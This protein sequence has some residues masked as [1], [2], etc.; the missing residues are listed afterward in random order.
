M[1]LLDN[2]EVESFINMCWDSWEQGWHESN[3]GNA[4]HRLTSETVEQISSFFNQE[5]EYILDVS[6][7]NIADEYF[8]ITGSGCQ[9]RNIKRYPSEVIGIIQINSEGSGYKLVWGLTAG[10]NPTMETT[11]HLLTHNAS[12]KRGNRSLL[13]SH[14]IALNSLTFLLEQDSK[15]YTKILWSMITECSIVFPEGVE[16]IDWMVCGSDQIGI[17][18]S[19]KM[20]KCN[21]VIWPH[22]GIF[23]IGENCDLAFGLLHTLEKSAAIYLNVIQAGKVKNSIGLQEVEQLAT[24]FSFNFDRSIYE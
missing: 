11:T 5:K 4:S 3:G 1:G 22:H 19:E 6:V 9:F 20:K 23:A 7:S 10:A 12:C 15:V 16:I 14:P 13:H 17:A 21:V 8:L 24:A 18:S 2:R